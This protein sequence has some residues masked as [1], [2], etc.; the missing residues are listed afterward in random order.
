M[1]KL[2][3]KYKV[4]LVG[5]TTVGKTSIINNFDNKKFQETLTQTSSVKS[6]IIKTLEL[7]NNMEIKLDIWDTASQELFRA[8]IKS[9]YSNAD[10]VIIVYD[11]KQKSSFDSIKNYW[12]K[13]VKEN[14]RENTLKNCFNYI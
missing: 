11:I 6:N 14:V 4:I 9:Y 12:L 5:D 2:K 3:S 7:D 10:G 8:L 13:E 1:K